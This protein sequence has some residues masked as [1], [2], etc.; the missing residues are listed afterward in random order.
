MPTMTAARAHTRKMISSASAKIISLPRWRR[1]A[2]RRL[3]IKS[4]GWPR[5]SWALIAYS[6]MQVRGARNTK[7]PS[8]P[9]MS[10]WLPRYL[11]SR[12]TAAIRTATI[13]P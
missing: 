13:R 7:P 10:H 1:N 3:R 6:P 8:I 5:S 4:G 11:A 9:N 2:A 12:L